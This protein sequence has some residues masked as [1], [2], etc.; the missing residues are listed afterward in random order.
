[1]TDKKRELMISGERS[2][3]VLALHDALTTLEGADPEHARVVEPHYFGGFSVDE[4]GEILEMSPR[5]VKL[6]NLGAF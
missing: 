3:E 2:S 1:M 6:F 5:I 4:I